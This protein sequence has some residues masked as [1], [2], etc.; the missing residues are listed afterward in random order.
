ML[1]EPFPGSEA[2]SDWTRLPTGRA[3]LVAE[4][5]RFRGDE[6]LA[7]TRSNPLVVKVYVFINFAKGGELF[8]IE[9]IRKGGAATLE[10]FLKF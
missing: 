2:K 6:F 10:N 5:D 1:P 8:G 4:V 7:L 3:A 9:R